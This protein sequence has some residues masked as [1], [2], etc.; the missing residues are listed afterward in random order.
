MSADPEPSEDAVPALVDLPEIV[1]AGIVRETAAV[2]PDLSVLPPALRRIADFAPQRRARLGARAIVT[3]LTDD[4]LRARVGTQVAARHPDLITGATGAD[5]AEAA[6]PIEPVDAAAWLWLIRP[7]GW[8][9]RLPDELASL[10]ERERAHDPQPAEV[11]RL[12][13]RLEQAEGAAAQ[14]RSKH[15]EQTDALKAENAELRRKLHL[16][17]AASREHEAARLTAE[18]E[19]ATAEAR[20]ESATAGADGETRRL[21]ARVAEL[22]RALQTARR[23]QRSG[24][25]QATLRARYL[26][27]ALV[28]AGQGLRRELGLPA[29]EGSPGSAAEDALAAAGG[30]TN[31]P[32]PVPSSRAALEAYL[33]LPRARLIIDGYNVSKSAWPEAPLDTQRNR[34]VSGLAALVARSGAETTVV[35]DAGEATTRMPVHPPRGVRVLFSPVGVIA[36]DVIR[37]LVAAEPT[38]RVVVVVTDDRAVVADVR[39]EGARVVGAAALL[40]TIGH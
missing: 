26:L 1:Q 39:R 10:A 14:Q 19:R 17:R 21:A 24:R 8:Q 30:A 15:R 28:E 31:A 2:L 38:G 40:E 27:D 20:A 16:A 11:A 5:T 3:A 35:F 9:E 7:E 22:E 13:R 23:D 34:L 32:A 18:Q 6:D 36:D 4:D 25:D 12:R 37:D 29:V 33:A